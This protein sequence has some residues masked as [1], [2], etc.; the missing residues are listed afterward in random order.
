[1]D[2]KDNVVA[3][4]N[5]MKANLDLPAEM[6]LDRAKE[7][8]LTDVVLVGWTKEDGALYFNCSMI[9]GPE[10]L[11]LLKQA[12]RHLLEQHDEEDD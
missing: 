3:L 7:V 1:M 11:W 2:K 4:P 9:D 6:I 10:A 12:E 5:I 8:G